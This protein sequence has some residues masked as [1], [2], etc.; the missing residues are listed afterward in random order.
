M[1]QLTHRT[2]DVRYSV[3]RSSFVPVTGPRGE[4]GAGRE[5]GTGLDIEIIPYPPSALIHIWY[6]EHHQCVKILG[7]NNECN[8]MPDYMANLG[9]VR[10]DM[11]CQPLHQWD[12][13]NNLVVL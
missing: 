10:S 3:P 7:K 6:T 5:E 11:E 2:S 13:L 12:Q 8:H 9:P 4:E 1:K